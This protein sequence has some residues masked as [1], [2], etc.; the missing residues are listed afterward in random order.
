MSESFLGS[1]MATLP[2]EVHDDS[3]LSFTTGTLQIL[4]P[5]PDNYA[6]LHKGTQASVEVRQY[7]LRESSRLDTNSEIRSKPQRRT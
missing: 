6:N 1:D 5:H 7:S 4:H 2:F 3:L